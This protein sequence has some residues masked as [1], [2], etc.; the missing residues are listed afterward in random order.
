MILI[1]YISLNDI[2]ATFTINTIVS[3]DNHI[4]MTISL[5]CDSN[6]TSTNITIPI[7][8]PIQKI[9]LVKHD[10]LVK[11]VE[12]IHKIEPIKHDEQDKPVEPVK[13]ST[14]PE[15][16][17]LKHVTVIKRLLDEFTQSHDKD[18]KV[19]K[20]I[21]ILNYISNEALEFTKNYKKFKNTIIN[22]CYEFKKYESHRRELVEKSD[23]VLIKLGASTTIPSD[24]I[25]PKLEQIR[26]NS[27]EI[28]TDTIP[29]KLVCTTNQP[30]VDALK[31][32]E[33]SAS[34]RIAK[35]LY[36]A[37]SIIESTPHNLY[38]TY[39]VCGYGYRCHCL[40]PSR[41]TLEI[42]NIWSKLPKCAIRII[43][44]LI[45]DNYILC[46]NKNYYH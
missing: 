42:G 4:E 31:K 36:K 24:F 8:L 39:V 15:S 10:E 32:A 38:T 34:P 20:A 29:K 14:Y 37:R 46:N 21:N 25:V 45:I 9:E 27:V 13:L 35:S 16:D 3:D 43:S 23:E 1:R 30:L 33:E 5:K 22:K 41:N 26:A 18:T 12:P 44:P 7:N 6:I 2:I 19:E 28:S 11:P 17:K 40:K